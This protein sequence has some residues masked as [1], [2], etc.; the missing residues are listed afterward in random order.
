[1]LPVNLTGP[2]G[3]HLEKAKAQ[4]EQDVEEGAGAVFLPHALARKYPNAERKWCWQYVFPSSRLSVDPREAVEEIL[5][6]QAGSLSAESGRMPDFRRR[7]RR[8]R[9]HI[10]ESYV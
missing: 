10:D 6:R 5:K 4:H 2:L 7:R 1:M 9:H 3:R 8:R